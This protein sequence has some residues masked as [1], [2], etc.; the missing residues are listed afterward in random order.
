MTFAA[1]SLHIC[2]LGSWSVCK[3]P[4][5]EPNSFRNIV[6][7]TKNKTSSDHRASL[8]FHTS[9]DC[10][11]LSQCLGQPPLDRHPLV[12]SS[13]SHPSSTVPAPSDNGSLM[14]T[15]AVC[16][17]DINT[18]DSSGNVTW[19]EENKQMNKLFE[20]LREKELIFH[21]GLLCVSSSLLRYS[22]IFFST[23]DLAC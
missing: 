3:G 20:S 19:K 13:V 8:Y 21:K 6:L 14:A 10:T 2:G 16:V 12:M 17:C 9:Q 7:A 5:K 15:G 1:W 18:S 22:T 4:R 23:N 11:P